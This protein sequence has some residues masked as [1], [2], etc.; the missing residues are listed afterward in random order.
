M[1]GVVVKFDAERGFGFLRA[2]GEPKEVFVHVSSVEGRATLEI[3]Q[4]V[5]FT[6]EETSKG[7]RALSVAPLRVARSAAA[8]FLMLGGA[9]AFVA[10]VLLGQWPQ[11]PWIVGYLIGINVATLAFFVYDGLVA[12]RGFVRVPR[13]VLRAFAFAGGTPVAIA[14]ERLFRRRPVLE[15]FRS[16][17]G[18]ALALQ[19]VIVVGVILYLRR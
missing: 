10:V 4:E 11:V 9:L 5:E 7:P 12:E 6:L 19:G 8:L 14:C 1:R 17:Y 18:I 13:G 3:G 15:S 2:R 16:A